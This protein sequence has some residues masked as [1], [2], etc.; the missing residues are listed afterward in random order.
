M[1]NSSL[2]ECKV[3]SNDLFKAISLLEGVVSNNPVI[4]IL[5]NLL[6]DIKTDTLTITGSDLHSTVVTKVK[7]D[8]SSE[9]KIAVPAT[10]LGNTLRNLP[11]Q[12]MVIKID[13]ENYTLVIETASGYY[14]MTCENHVDFPPIP[15][16]EDQKEIQCNISSFKNALKKTLFAA[17]KDEMHPN[18]CGVNLSFYADM[19]VFAAT[20]GHRLVRYQLKHAIQETFPSI[21][22]PAK[23][24]QLLLSLFSN[25]ALEQIRLHID[26]QHAHFLTPK[27][28]V[29]TSLIDDTYPDIDAVIPKKHPYE[30][31]VSTKALREAVK[32]VDYYAS[33]TTHE[34]HLTLGKD[35]LKVDAEDREFSNHGE[36]KV[37]CQYDGTPMK[38]G[39]NARFFFEM[40]KNIPSEE[41]KIRCHDAYKPL[42]VLPQATQ[43]DDVLMLIMPLAFRQP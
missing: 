29:V 4:P 21:T 36:V 31:M 23:A 33:K 32:L 6:F 11:P 42:L 43:G 2:I 14:R 10:I 27:F 40:L 39:L 5:S 3:S 37:A 1:N 18:I 24:T 20:D 17:S 26:A 35:L 28:H 34:M 41:L 19:I 22:L 16:V 9:G 13:L 12:P 30:V 15:A 25:N 8:A 38:I 7:V